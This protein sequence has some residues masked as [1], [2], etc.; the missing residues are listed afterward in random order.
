[1]L[2]FSRKKMKKAAI[3]KATRRLEDARRAIQRIEKAHYYNEFESAWAEFLTAFN[4]I[5]N[6]LSA[7]ARNHLKSQPWLGRKIKQRRDD[8]LLR[9]LKQARDTEEHGLEPVTELEPGYISIGAQGGPVH[10]RSLEIDGQG[11][12]SGDISTP[13]GGS[14]VVTKKPASAKL[15]TVTD[16][17][18]GHSVDP[19]KE[20]LETKLK[21]GSPLEVARTGL[22]Y[23]ELLIDE[24]KRYV[25]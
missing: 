13:G 8:P 12:I 1:M 21:N 2:V 6:I 25:E 9:Y 15:V 5:Y 16:G 22:G 7:G 19:P 20:H 17:R 10:I 4:A 18:F 11:N 24:A 3:D 14:L 23:L